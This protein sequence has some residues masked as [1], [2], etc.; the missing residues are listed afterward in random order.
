LTLRA[1][2]HRGSCPGRHDLVRARDLGR[3][4]GTAGQGPTREQADAYVDERLA[5]QKVG[6]ANDVMYQ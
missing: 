6:D 1:E 3:Q 5:N 2:P 4:P